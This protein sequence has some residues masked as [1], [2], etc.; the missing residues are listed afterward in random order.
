MRLK[1]RLEKLERAARDNLPCRVCGLRENERPGYRV[2]MRPEPDD[3]P[4]FCPGCGRKFI[5]TIKFDRRR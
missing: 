5:Y 4:E 1:L 3:G 2:S